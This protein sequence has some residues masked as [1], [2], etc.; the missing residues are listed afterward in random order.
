MV[1]VMMKMD[2][3][4][5]T[6]MT[7]FLPSLTMQG[8]IT[9][10]WGQRREKKRKEI[11]PMDLNQKWGLYTLL[12]KGL[13]C[14]HVYLCESLSAIPTDEPESKLDQVPSVRE[15]KGAKGGGRWPA[16][17][18]RAWLLRKWLC[19][20]LGLCYRQ[21]SERRNKALLVPKKILVKRPCM[22]TSERKTLEVWAASSLKSDKTSEKE[23][24]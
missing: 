23:R 10:S 18:K 13:Q 8:L 3:G 5:V 19:E 6:E 2:V 11:P 21:C 15:H 14:R 22:I 12:N 9:N 4:M 24:A 17:L 1:M 20:I 7:S 16:W